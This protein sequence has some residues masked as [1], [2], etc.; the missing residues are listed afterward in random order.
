MVYVQG[1]LTKPELYDDLR[2]A[3]DDAEKTLG[4]QGNAIFY[5]AIADRLFGPVVEQLGKA[6]LTD[7]NEDRNGKPRFPRGDREAVR[8]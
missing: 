7:Q 6:K 5:L 3:L 2:G 8:P 4:T 1:D